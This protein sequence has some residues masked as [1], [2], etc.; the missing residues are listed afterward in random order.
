MVSSF[1]R[2][3][4]EDFDAERDLFSVEE[5]VETSLEDDVAST[6]AADILVADELL[7][8]YQN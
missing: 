7:R 1:L 4:V 6:A 5:V 2:R 3:E 8:T